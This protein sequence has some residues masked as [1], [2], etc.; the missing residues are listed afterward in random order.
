MSVNMSDQGSVGKLGDDANCECE[1]QVV[2]C[3]TL[4]DYIFALPGVGLIN[5]ISV[6][7]WHLCQM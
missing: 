5:Q 4:V 2:V 7:D 1:S 6:S 3:V